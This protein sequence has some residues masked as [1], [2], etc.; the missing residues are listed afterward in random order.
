MKSYIHG[1]VFSVLSLLLAI[2]SAPVQAASKAEVEEQFQ[3]W[4]KADLWP[5][6]EK[7][8][9][10]RKVFDAATA[11]LK[12]D[13]DLPDLVPPGSAPP[14]DRSQSQA[15]F[16]SPGAYFSEK[17]LQGLA[18][19]GRSLAAKHAGT[20]RRIEATYGVPGSVI[21]AIWGR[22][23]GFGQAKLPHPAIEVL[24]TKA[25]MSTRKDLFTRELISALH[26][27][28]GG[29]IAASRMMGSWAGALGQPQF[30]PT[31]YLKYAVDF[32][33]DGHRDIWN[34]VPDSLASI[35]NY[36]A[37]S[38]WQRGRDWGFEVSIPAG[39]SCAQEGPDKAQ[40][41][42]KWA[43]T[44]IKR[45]SGKAFPKAELGERTMMLMPAGTH[46]PEFL[47]SPNFYVIKEYNNSD[48]YALFIGNLADRIAHGS[49]AFAGAW[50]DVGKMLRSDVLA[51]QKALVAKGYDVG[52]VD[53]L[54]G[55]K[56]RRSLGDWQ[57]K[58]GMAPTCYPDSSLKAKLR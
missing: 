6:A 23:S 17:R 24:A 33:G 25:F 9:V 11:D 35:A 13:W 41:L 29:D 48:L 16:S 3:S 14:K 36:L 57:Q 4:L 27:V 20:L 7:S 50:G 21:V 15:E 22:E 31:S 30:L 32:D 1:A 53:G 58:S 51:M 49:G 18:G 55:F 37:K 42:S 5:Q 47:V 19:T 44:G 26:I 39:V 56:T 8:G 10:S 40:P 28:E 38:G 52:T 43:A 45:I 46:G 12:L 2:P 54:P 34:S